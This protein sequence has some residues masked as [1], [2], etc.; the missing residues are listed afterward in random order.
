MNQS[1]YIIAV[2]VDGPRTDD[3]LTRTYARGR[4]AWN[5]ARRLARHYAGD[6]TITV[7]KVA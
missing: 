2:S 6:A 4:V 1:C 7:V 5:V 3:W